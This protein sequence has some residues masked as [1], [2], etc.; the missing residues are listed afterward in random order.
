M[1]KINQAFILGAGRGERM[2]PLTDNIP[3]PLAK[4]K[5]KAIIDYIIEKLSALSTIDRIIVN[6]HYL[7]E[8]LEEHLYSLNNSKI[9]ISSEKEKLETGGGLINAM[10]FFDQEKPILIINGDIFWIDQNNS[11][12]N[13]MIDNFDDQKMDILL[14]LKPKDRFFGYDGSGDF[15]FNKTNGEII[16]T[17]DKNHSHTY[18]GIQIFHPKILAK[19]P[20]DRTFSLNYFFIQ[21]IMGKGVLDRICGLEI[22]EDV[23]HISTIADLSLINQLIQ[24]S[25]EN[26][27]I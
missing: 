17:G 8:I 9:I 2:R 3:K 12:L 14:A 21:S 25:L 24:F 11:L 19:R 7:S 23:F 4:I 16:K 26:G 6:S 10:P 20:V 1:D 15:N 13:K 22:E 27:K 5:G 18:I